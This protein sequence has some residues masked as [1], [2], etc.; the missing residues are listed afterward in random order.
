MADID[1]EFK[2]SLNTNGYYK[3]DSVID[4]ESIQEMQTAVD[5]SLN[6]KSPAVRQNHFF[7]AHN[8]D[9]VF[10]DFISINPLQKYVDEI[11]G[12]TCIIH[13]Y[14]GITLK[15]TVSNPI[16]N[17]VHRDS[18]RFCRPFLLSLQI[19]IMLDDFTKENGATY[20]LPGSHYIED[21]PV[22]ELF[23][24]NAIQVEGKAGDAVIFDSMLWHAGGTNT[25][26]KQRRA[27]T[28][29]YT[30]SFMRQQIDLTRATNPEIVLNADEKIKRLLGFNVRVPSSIEEFNLP[31]SERLYKPNQG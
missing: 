17:A 4:K 19:L 23:Y 13:S 31:T 1:Y 10:L 22:D 16:Q 20:I 5:N 26:A 8:F 28:L 11:L 21:K 12:N 2:Y 3:F 29:V 6:S 25:T 14:N 15:P 30:R 9:K 27:L 7:M 18:P 24:K